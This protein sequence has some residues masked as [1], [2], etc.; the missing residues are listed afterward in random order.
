[1]GVLWNNSTIGLGVKDI[2]I[3]ILGLENSSAVTKR[4]VT[5]VWNKEGEGPAMER[6]DFF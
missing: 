6:N 1:M 5:V 3:E 4:C 2:G